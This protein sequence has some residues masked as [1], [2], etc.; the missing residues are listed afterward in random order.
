MAIV[1]VRRRSERDEELSAVGVRS[2]VRHR[3]DASLVVPQL[4]VKL[5]GEVIAGAA[6]T[7]T[8]RIAALNHELVDDA[9][10]NRAVV[11]GFVHFLIRA[12]IAPLLGAFRQPDKILDRSRHLLIEQPHGEISFTGDKLRVGFGHVSHRGYHSRAVQFR[13]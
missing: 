8:K 11:V 1:E 5:V 2:S 13:P 10:K 12:W 6:D 3:E 4:G 7:L 9:M